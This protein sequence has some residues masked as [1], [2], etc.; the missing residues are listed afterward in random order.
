MNATST[1]KLLDLR[2]LERVAS[3]QRALERGGL[4][5]AEDE[6]S[7]IAPGLASDDADTKRATIR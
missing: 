5:T 3:V 4:P 1:D 7:N 2:E 6:V